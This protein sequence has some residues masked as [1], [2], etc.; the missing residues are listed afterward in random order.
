MALLLSDG[1]RWVTFAGGKMQGRCESTVNAGSG[2]T[3]DPE[4]RGAE[5]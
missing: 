1:E 3:G 2:Q 4:S 5:S